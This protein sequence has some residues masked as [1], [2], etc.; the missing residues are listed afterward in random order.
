[1]ELAKDEGLVVEERTLPVE[2]LKS[3]KEV[4]ACGTA[5]VVTP[6]N[7]IVYKDEVRGAAGWRVLTGSRGLGPWPSASHVPPLASKCS[8]LFCLFAVLMPVLPL[9]VCHVCANR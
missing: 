7:R 3:L 4:A 9:A 6:V 8:I 1:M 2:E 5:V